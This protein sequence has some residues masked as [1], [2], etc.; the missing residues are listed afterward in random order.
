MV[1]EQ[2]YTDE[3][4]KI[5]R[6]AKA[7]SHPVRV[8]ILDYIANHTKTCCYS[9]DL[10]ENLNIARSTLSEHLRELKESG[11]IQG[12]INPPYIKYC[13]NREN[14]AIAKALF[15]NFFID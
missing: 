14:W 10:H 12:E 2:I 7:L 1:K 6:I 3:Q 5:A 11:L 13:I 15:G 8:Y 4:Q 9:G